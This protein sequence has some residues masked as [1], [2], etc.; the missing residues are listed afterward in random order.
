MDMSKDGSY[1]I[2]AGISNV[3][4]KPMLIC[5]EMNKDLGL[6]SYHFFDFLTPNENMKIKRIQGYD[7]FIVSCGRSIS[8][9]Q[10]A[11]FKFHLIINYLDVCVM[12]ITDFQFKNGCIWIKE[13]G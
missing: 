9:V 10:L 13:T 7:I 4:N 1:F 3:R 6:V 11:N 8:V 5:A 2:L 12:D